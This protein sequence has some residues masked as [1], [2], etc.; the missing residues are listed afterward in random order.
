MSVPLMNIWYPSFLSL[1]EYS[2][3]FGPKYLLQ[4]VINKFLVLIFNPIKLWQTDLGLHEHAFLHNAPQCVK[5]CCYYD[6]QMD[7]NCLI[8][9]RRPC[10]SMRF[11]RLALWMQQAASLHVKSLWKKQPCDSCAWEIKNRQHQSILIKAA[12]I[13]LADITDR[14]R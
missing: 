12:V 2:G 8:Q 1:V 9:S 5:I 4:T 10:T 7:N 3:W 6:P 14:P 13:V 11:G